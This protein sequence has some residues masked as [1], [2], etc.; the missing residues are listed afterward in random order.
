MASVFTVLASATAP[1]SEMTN[2]FGALPPVWAAAEAASRIAG[3]IERSLAIG[4]APQFL[5]RIRGYLDMTGGR[6]TEAEI[7]MDVVG[8]SA[9]YATAAAPSQANDRYF[10]K[11]K[12]CSIRRSEEHTS[13]L[14]S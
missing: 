2:R 13:E 14:Q 1:K 5:R 6:R 12:L 7:K 9:E 3:I 8:C 11:P 10:A 4:L